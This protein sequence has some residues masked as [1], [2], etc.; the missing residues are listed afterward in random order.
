M[1]LIY[2]SILQQIKAIYYNKSIGF[3]TKIKETTVI[4]LYIFNKKKEI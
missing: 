2:I 4:R 3:F 1:H